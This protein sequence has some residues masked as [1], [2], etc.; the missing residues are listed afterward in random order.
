M[1][2]FAVAKDPSNNMPEESPVSENEIL[3]INNAFYDAFA[4]QFEKIP[5]E[6]L[7]TAYFSKYAPQRKGKRV[8]DIGSGPGVFA[9]WMQNKGFEVLCVEPSAEMYRRCKL[10]GLRAIHAP[11]EK[12]ALKEKFDHIFALSSL[13]HIPPEHLTAVL[14]AISKFV[15]K[16]GYFYC[17]FL[18]GRKSGME[19]PTATGKMRYFCRLEAVEIHRLLAPFFNVLEETE[20]EVKRMKSRFLLLVLQKK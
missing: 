1:A 14:Q 16:N 9:A 6:D 17:S 18:I 19:D 4:D 20:V 12:I 8:L 3:E 11:I 13:I 5:F 15:D 2:C 7:I 10:K